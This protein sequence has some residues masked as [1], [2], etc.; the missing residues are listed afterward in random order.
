MLEVKIEA[1][2]A[3]QMLDR[4][5]QLRNTKLGLAVAALHLKGKMASYPSHTPRPQAQYWSDKQRRGFFY[6]LKQ[7]NIDVPY[8]RGMSRKSKKL[9]QSWTNEARNN[10]LTQVIGTAV[11]YAPLVQSAAK[12]TQY[13]KV[14]GWKTE[15][16]VI[17]DEAANVN[18]IVNQYIQRDM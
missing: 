18:K 1:S 5:R 11:S 7:G 14:T 16:Q 10:G 3:S 2:A 13:H 8:K 6:H 4:L 15:K 12:Q 17:A 9:G